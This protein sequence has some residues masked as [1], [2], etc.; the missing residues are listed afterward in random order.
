MNEKLWII[1]N[2]LDWIA[3]GAVN[4][5]VFISAYVCISTTHHRCRCHLGRPSSGGRATEQILRMQLS[6]DCCCCFFFL[7]TKVSRRIA[8]KA[9]DSVVRCAH[10]IS[11]QH[12]TQFSKSVSLDFFYS[13]IDCTHVSKFLNLN[14]MIKINT[15]GVKGSFPSICIICQPSGGIGE[16][17]GRRVT[18]HAANRTANVRRRNA[19]TEVLSC[20]WNDV[21]S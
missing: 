10:T 17:D 4:S 7:Y 21:C 12:S 3:V 13:R 18:N 20:N 15:G 8:A 9:I 14:H 16:L 19:T 5:R 11:Q 1:R 6:I 2:G